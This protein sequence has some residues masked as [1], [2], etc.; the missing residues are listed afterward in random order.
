MSLHLGKTECILFGPRKKLNKVKEFSVT[1]DDVIIK[2]SHSVNYLGVT[3]DR[4]LT[5]EDTVNKVISK[6]N[7]R[8]KFL[9]RNAAFLNYRCR[10][11][12]CTSL[13]QCHID[14]CASAWYYCISATSK[15]KLQVIQN[16]MVRYIC[17]Q[18]SRFHVG[19]AELNSLK[20]LKVNLR[21]RQ[22]SLNKVFDIF[23]DSCPIYMK[24]FFTKV[25]SLHTHFIRGSQFNFVVPKITNVT[26]KSFFYNGA[27]HWNDLP[28]NIKSVTD[29]NIFKKKVKAYLS[30]MYDS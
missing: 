10:R 1:V 8:L 21:V 19:L 11:I 18:H 25:Y 7:A 29:K 3:L 13:I 30:N 22:L 9:Y 4:G 2:A 5:G 17:K 15:L 6:A 24:Q 20:M 23:H 27:K 26:S 12:L 28:N 16:K 14:Y